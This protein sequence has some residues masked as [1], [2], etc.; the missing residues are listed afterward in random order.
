M[1]AAAAERIAGPPSS[2]SAP[3][4]NAVLLAIG[5]GA[6]AGVLAGFGLGPF[7]L[8]AIPIL[9]GCVLGLLGE[10]PLFLLI[11]MAASGVGFYWAEAGLLIAGRAINLSGLHWGLLGITAGILLLRKRPTGVPRPL[12]LY[13]VYLAVAA[14]AVAW[15]PDRFEGIKQ[16]ILATLPLLMALVV[17]AYLTTRAEL[18]LVVDA[19][20]VAL[21]VAV[22]TAI[23]MWI[24]GHRSEGLGGGVG[25]RTF[26]IFLLPLMALALASVRHR[27]GGFVWV[28]LAIVGVAVATLSRTAV[29]VMLLL[30]LFATRGLRPPVRLAML[31]LAVV[32]GVSALNLGAFRARFGEGRVQVSQVGV[33]GEGASAALTVGS[34]NLTGRGWIWVQVWRRA[35]RSPVIGHGT[36]SSTVY[37]AGLPRSPAAH[38]HNDYLRVFHDQGAIGLLAILAFGGAALL[39]FGGMHRR[40]EDRPTKRLALA[41]YLAT[42]AYG[43]MAV[44]D[45][46]LIYATFFTQNVFVL[47]ALT[48]VARRVAAD[49]TGAM[50]VAGQGARP[51]AGDERG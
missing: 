1:P 47:Y 38:P 48:E 27:S 12:I 41:S 34:V 30:P 22:A 14:V 42:L 32:L 29:L 23:G 3:S 18:R 50:P 5:L 26:A 31:G 24:A 4:Y 17:L 9:V 28:A 36:G 7:A 10:V 46:P 40:A 44:T 45:N 49:E 51:A 35:V 15:A 19:Y 13:G 16:L 39:H 25:T 21:V 2:P 20:W 8:A 11:T 6:P 33:E 37:L 43:A